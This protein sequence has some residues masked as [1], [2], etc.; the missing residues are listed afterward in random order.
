MQASGAIIDPV[1]GGSAVGDK[2]VMVGLF[3]SLDIKSWKFFQP[4]IRP[5]LIEDG[6]ALQPALVNWSINLGTTN[7][8]KMDRA[9][10]IW[11]C[12]VIRPMHC[13]TCLKIG[14]KLR[15]HPGTF[16]SLAS[17]PSLAK[18]ILPEIQNFFSQF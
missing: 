12:D 14:A 8:L 6:R 9:L 11:S 4:L 10:K 15:C 16:G 2:N 7:A 5:K 18:P 1:K 13:L 3:V 17:R